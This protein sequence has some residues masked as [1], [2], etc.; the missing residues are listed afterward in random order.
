MKDGDRNVSMFAHRLGCGIAAKDGS[1]ID[2]LVLVRERVERFI[3][4]PGARRPALRW[5]RMCCS[6][7]EHRK[8]RPDIRVAPSQKCKVKWP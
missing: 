5:S 3:Q 2:A 4:R 8:I 6:R 7:S 1:Q